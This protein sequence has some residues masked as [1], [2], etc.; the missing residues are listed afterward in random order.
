MVEIAK[1]SP[2]S[3][4]CSENCY[5]LEQFAELLRHDAVHIV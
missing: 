3:I 1:R 4:A 2:V 5:R